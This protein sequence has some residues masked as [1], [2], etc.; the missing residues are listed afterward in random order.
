MAKASAQPG[1]V[2]FG[3]DTKGY[4]VSVMTKL[5]WILSYRKFTGEDIQDAVDSPGT[6]RH[7]VIVAFYKSM[8]IDIP[9]FNDC[10]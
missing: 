7:V 10:Q 4:I 6:S 3:R 1:S 8:T 2:P 9:Y 5:S